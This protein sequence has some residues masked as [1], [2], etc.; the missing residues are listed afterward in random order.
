MVM[1]KHDLSKIST[2]GGAR[3]N[4]K[5]GARI[6]TN[7]SLKTKQKTRT[8]METSQASTSKLKKKNIKC[9][10]CGKKGHYA[11]N[12]FKKKN[13]FKQANISNEKEDDANASEGEGSL[14]VSSF[15][16]SPFKKDGSW[17]I[18]SGA[19]SHMCSSKD[20]F[21]SIIPYEGAKK[22][23]YTANDQECKIE[24][25]GTIS[26]KLAYSKVLSLHKV[27]FVPKLTKNLISVG[28]LLDNGLMSNSILTLV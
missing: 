17:Y 8:K 5:G 22:F 19:S 9:F 26:L 18:D 12:C 23:I 27:L 13:Q 7:I 25:V 11:T 3:I 24:G 15:S 4:T 20:S 16:S 6:N 21:S 28:H 2:K 10:F 1:A 14:M